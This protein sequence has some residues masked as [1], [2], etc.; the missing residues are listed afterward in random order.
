MKDEDQPTPKPQPSSPPP[1]PPR[2]PTIATGFCGDDE[3][4][5]KRQPKK[6]TVRINLPPGKPVAAPFI[7]LPTL[8][9]TVR[10]PAGT[11]KQKPWWKFW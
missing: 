8:A 6:E 4:E 1:R 11:P 2:G 7:K 3:P 10:V 5:P 9:P